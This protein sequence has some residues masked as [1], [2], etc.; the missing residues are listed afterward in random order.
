MKRLPEKYAAQIHGVPNCYDRIVI[1]GHLQ[2]L[3]YAKGMTKYL[4]KEQ[5]RI[6]DYK[7]FAQPLR[8]LIRENAALIAQE[9][10]Y[11]STLMDTTGWLPN[12]VVTG[13][14]LFSR[15]THFCRSMASTRRMPSSRRHNHDQVSAHEKEHLQPTAPQEQL[16]A[17]NR[18]YE[19]F[20]SAVETP[21]IGV[22]KL[23]S[24]TETKTVKQRRYKGFHLL[25]EEEASLLRA[26]LRDEFVIQGFTN[27]ALR[28][29]L[30][31]FNAAQVTRLIKRLWVHGVIKRVERRYKYYLTE[32]GRQAATMAL[33]L[34][35]TVIIPP[36]AQR[37]DASA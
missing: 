36:F 23:H 17:T 2:L 8:D 35:E 28:Q 31:N 5:I 7:E 22:R 24:L 20:I 10:G 21:E 32:L 9:L 18:R 16:V 27:R 4:Y 30:G 25:S 13:S 33:K 26:L 19:M 6:F 15:R 14:T 3:S 34:S 12:C 37:L 11:S 29:H 1:A